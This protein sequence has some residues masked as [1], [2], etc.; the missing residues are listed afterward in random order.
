[1]SVALGVPQDGQKGTTAADMRH[2][3]ASLFTDA[4]LV[5]GLTVKGTNALY[6]KVE[7]GVCV[8]SRGVSDG[9]TLAYFP[10]GNTP[11][12]A[13]NASSFSRI[14]TI[15][16]KA[17]DKTQGDATNDVIVGVEQGVP[18]Q[19]PTH[20]VA[21]SGCT[22][23]AFVVLPAGATNTSTATATMQPAYATPYSISG[24][25]LVNDTYTQAASVASGGW[26]TVCKGDFYVPT[27]RSIEITS[28][29][30][31]AAKDCTDLNW[32][33]A[34]YAEIAIDGKTFVDHKFTRINGAIEDSGWTDYTTVEAGQHHIEMYIYGS[35]AYPAS[36]LSLAYL[37]NSYP[38]QT[39]I[40]IDN[41]MAY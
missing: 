17:Q 1:M 39:L 36:G 30:S 24:R 33:G 31:A 4:G 7:P 27:R 22:P 28:G 18:A 40:V 12:V 10:G 32:C 5:K 37:K 14:D 21:P 34:G 9:A 2:I 41:G 8:C 15:W 6:Y 23:I 11:T 13:A 29:V 19:T 3:I 38:G 16:L 25:M 35:Q 20:G 26:L